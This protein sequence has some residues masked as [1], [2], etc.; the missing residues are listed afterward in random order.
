[1]LRVDGVEERG[2]GLPSDRKS[3]AK[4]TKTPSNRKSNIPN[5]TDEEHD[6]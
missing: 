1:M 3:E 5:F 2:R 6:L 4:K